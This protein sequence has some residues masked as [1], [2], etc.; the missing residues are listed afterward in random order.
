MKKTTRKN[1][2]KAV[3]LSLLLSLSTATTFAAN[4]VTDLN[5]STGKN[6]ISASTN[7]SGII[8]AGNI[9][10]NAQNTSIVGMNNSISNST[11][12]GV[13]GGNNQ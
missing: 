12:S 5:L 9:V 6:T 10:N 7:D 11:G 13:N 1:T 2:E 3:I 8:G 4:V